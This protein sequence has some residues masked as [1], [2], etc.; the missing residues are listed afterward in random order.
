MLALLYIS[1]SP[2]NSPWTNVVSHCCW[3][4]CKF[5][6]LFVVVGVHRWLKW[7]NIGLQHKLFGTGSTDMQITSFTLHSIHWK[8][9][10]KIVSGGHWSYTTDGVARLS[11]NSRYYALVYY[12]NS[13]RPCLCLKGQIYKYQ[14][15]PGSSDDSL[16]CWVRHCPKLPIQ[17]VNHLMIL[18][19][20]LPI[21]FLFQNTDHPQGEDGNATEGHS[22]DLPIEET[23][24]MPSDKAHTRTLPDPDIIAPG[25]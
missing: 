14:S 23:E 21:S 2:K 12:L 18:L 25:R 13:R 3:K 6:F 9:V 24:K 1:C 22:S 8:R 7:C 19:T 5:D 16:I 20:T 10:E 15:F 11:C 4:T 17:S